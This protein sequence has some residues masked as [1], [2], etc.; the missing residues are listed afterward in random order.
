MEKIS[1]VIPNYNRG[2]LLLE[3]IES[4]FNQPGVEVEVI[5][6][7]DGSSDGSADKAKDRFPNIELIKQKNQ[8]ACVARNRGLETASGEYIKFIDSDDT[9]APSALKSQVEHIQEGGHDVVYGDFK[10]FGNLSDARVGAMPLRITGDVDDLI[11]ALLGEWWCAPFCYLY[12]REALKSVRWRQD[13]EC[14][15]DFDFILKVALSGATFSYRSGVIGYYRMHEG[16]ITNSNAAKYAKN[17]IRVL[18]EALIGL[19]ESRILSTKR[20]DLIA[21]GYWS[22]S[23]AYYE[24]DR[25][26]FASV[27]KKVYQ[28]SPKFYP[29]F[30]GSSSLRHMTGILGI[31]KTELLVAFYRRLRGDKR[32][33]D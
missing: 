17:R 9:L 10:M 32:K 18:D 3:T 20:K 31:K 15:Q 33:V 26:E 13:L 22:A 16:Q 1:I 2:S 27:V 11:N 7:D 19:E 5:V 14:L 25:K 30:W 21:H 8:G 4:C 29:S 23:R 12:R 28:L 6:V 24:S